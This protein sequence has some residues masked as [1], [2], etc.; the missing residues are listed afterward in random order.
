M[1]RVEV[2]IDVPAGIDRVWADVARLDTHVEWMSDAESIE[3]VG[4]S[5]GGVG[6]VMRVATRIGPLRT[7]DVIRVVSWNPPESIGV[8]HEGVVT[9]V[10]EFRLA[11]IPTGTRFTWSEDLHLPWFLGGRLGSAIAGPV[12]ARVWRR[13]LQRLADRFA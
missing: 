3:F 10:G 5:T 8:I 9:G 6:T 1:A 13:N 2:G 11:A 12:L 7:S 4:S